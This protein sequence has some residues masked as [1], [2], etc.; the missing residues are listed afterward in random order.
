MYQKFAH[1]SILTKQTLLYLLIFL[2]VGGIVAVTIGSFYTMRGSL[3]QVIHQDVSRVIENANLSRELS[4]VV[5]DTNLL[6]TT[7]AEDDE[8]LGSERERLL[9]ILD[10]LIADSARHAQQTGLT[11]SLRAFQTALRTLLDQCVVVNDNLSDIR[12]LDSELHRMIG[13]V[14]ALVAE[15]LLALMMDGREEESFLLDQLGVLFPECREKLFEVTLHINAMTQTHLGIQEVEH[16]YIEEI[17]A[18][19]DAL[20]VKL[21]SI[22][23]AGDDFEAAGIALLET[24]QNY[25]E[26]IATLHD[27]FLEFQTRFR[28]VKAEQAQMNTM[29]AAMDTEIRDTTGHLQQNLDE[30]IQASVFITAIL[31]GLVLIVLLGALYSTM[32]MIRPITHLAEAANQLASGNITYD[33]P[34]SRSQDEVGRLLTAMKTMLG[35]LKDV[36]TDVRSA[37]EHVAAGSQAMSAS[38]NQMSQGAAIQASSSEEAS[39]SMEQMAANIRQNA[40]N[41]LQTEKIAISAAED[42]RQGKVAVDKAVHAMQEIAKKIAIIEDIAQQTRMLSLNATIEAARA[43]E[44]GRGF[45]V[46][47]SEVRSL[48]ERSQNAATEINGLAGSSVAI[49]EH[50]GEM[51]Q[52]LVPNIQKTAELVQEIAAAS[53]EQDSGASQINQAIQQLDQVTQQHSATAEELSA[54]TDELAAQAEHLQGTIA[55]FNVD[56]REEEDAVPEQP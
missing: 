45:A 19:L 4:D 46:V 26:R 25:R 21:T 10:R 24:T 37:A 6:I 47:A 36:V 16:H 40:D 7:F 55:F 8:L 11:D 9:T 3:T 23:T 41:A 30:A 15:K 33:I 56:E 38:A 29:L 52:K 28:T 53:N 2:A 42:A 17:A 35:K 18:L 39:A 20:E 50:A 13:E 34:E 22:R 48:A 27:A 44:H 12:A 14:E 43:Q 54:M 31:S 49:V 51:L 32:R 1:W 5:A